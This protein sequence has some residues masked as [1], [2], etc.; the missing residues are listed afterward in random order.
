M[1]EVIALLILAVLLFGSSKVLGALGMI[2]GF[3]A[4]IA[5]FGFLSFSLGIE[6]GTLLFSV[7]GMFIVLLLAFGVWDS[8]RKK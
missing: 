6:P 3:V 4:T 1:L 8:L 7:G 2:A 5:A